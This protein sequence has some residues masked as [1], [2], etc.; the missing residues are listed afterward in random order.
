MPIHRVECLDR[1]F[2]E[3]VDSMGS[4]RRVA[5]AAWVSTDRAEDR[6]ADEVGKVL[7][8]MA[9]HGHWTPF[10]HVMATFRL[11]MPI[12]VARQWMRSNIGIVYNEESRRYVD[13]EPEFYRPEVWRARGAGVKQGSGEGVVL[14]DPK[15]AR[16][17]WSNEPIDRT[18]FGT[19][20]EDI[21]LEEYR[22]R[23]EAGI[24]PE[25][26]RA[27]LPLST[28]TEMV[29]TASIAAYARVYALR[30]DPHAQLEAQVYGRALDHFLRPKFP[31]AWAA[32]VGG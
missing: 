12:F 7:G 16:V 2:V 22:R 4:D 27:C 25:L 21:A 5:E 20:A 14:Y 30:V 23:L 26:A 1:G 28:Y 15:Q 31:L 6:T 19:S 17:E 11:K 8:Y 3:F 32:L 18:R 9:R 24:A 29:M 13:R 10:G